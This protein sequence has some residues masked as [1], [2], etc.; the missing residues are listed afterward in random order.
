[1]INC[2]NGCLNCKNLFFEQSFQG[3]V[4]LKCKQGYKIN[5]SRNDE[6]TYKNLDLL[7]ISVYEFINN[8]GV[9]YK[10]MECLGLV[11]YKDVDKYLIEH[12]KDFIVIDLKQLLP[13]RALSYESLEAY[14]DD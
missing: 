5:V 6:D 12:D 4:T 3:Y 13:I 10:D 1:M 8:Y 7:G 11:D 14:L 9:L 2:D